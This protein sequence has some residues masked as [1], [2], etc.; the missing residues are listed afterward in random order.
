MRGSGDGGIGHI[1]RQRSAAACDRACE[2]PDPQDEAGQDRG[3]GLLRPGCEGAV[4]GDSSGVYWCES[5]DGWCVWQYSGCSK[6]RGEDCDEDHSG[7]P[8]HWEC[9]WACGRAEAAKGL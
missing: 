7:I 9:P 5:A 6:Y 4:P 8:L 3:G 1:R 2:D